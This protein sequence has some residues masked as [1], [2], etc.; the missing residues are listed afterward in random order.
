MGSRE[1]MEHL[2]VPALRMVSFQSNQVK[3]WKRKDLCKN[4]IILVRD[5]QAELTINGMMEYA[6]PGAV[7]FFP[8]GT[9]VECQTPGGKHTALTLV[10][11]TCLQLSRPDKAWTALEARFSVCG[12]LDLDDSAGESSISSAIQHLFSFKGTDNRVELRHALHNVLMA[13]RTSSQSQQDLGQRDIGMRTALVYMEANYTRELKLSQLAAMAGLSENHFIR[14]FKRQTGLTPMVYMTKLRMRRA[15]ELLFGEVKIK[16]I[17]QQVGYQDEH[18]FSRIFKK[19]EG[20]APTMYLKQGAPRLAAMYYGLDDCLLTLGLR[21]VAALSYRERVTGSSGLSIDQNQRQE[22][23]VQ[24]V[25]SKLDYDELKGARPD[26]ILT[27]DRLEVDEATTRIASTIRIP[28]SNDQGQLLNNLGELFGKKEQAA[29]W[30]QRYETLKHTYQ[31]KLRERLGHATVCFIRVGPTFYRV[32]GQHNQTGS[33]L[34][35]DLGLTQSGLYPSS[36]WAL[37]LPLDD[38]SHYAADY[39]L[40]A[41]D[42]TDAARQRLR[43]LLQSEQWKSMA[44]VRQGRVYDTSDLL[45]KTLG[46]SGKL[47]AMER[48]GGLLLAAK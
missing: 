28:Y 11:F 44:A 24:L 18:Y 32:Y 34:Y 23:C 40:L 16:T 36:E 37:D 21:P 15:K 35:G 45:F 43:E 41:V 29:S 12:R 48:V 33:L 22:G 46:P 20:V 47:W 1:R 38:L 4:A 25:A 2:Y 9:T 8:A 19:A 6:Q 42:P 14:I 30:N 26:L 27:S 17:A 31:T 7:Y 13:M 39:L 3:H 5:S 10:L